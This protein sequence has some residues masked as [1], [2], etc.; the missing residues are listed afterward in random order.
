M[1]AI[2]TYVTHWWNILL[3]DHLA[4]QSVRNDGDK[5]EDTTNTYQTVDIWRRKFH[6][7]E[8]KEKKEVIIIY[9]RSYLF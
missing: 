4:I 3:G 5:E 9:I 7:S 2:A 6:E 8:D 1:C